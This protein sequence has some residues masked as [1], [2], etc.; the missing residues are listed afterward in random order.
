MKKETASISINSGISHSEKANLLLCSLPQFEK[1][2]K[3]YFSEGKNL[4]KNRGLLENSI[5]AKEKLSE[6]TTALAWAWMQG[7]KDLFEGNAFLMKVSEVDEVADIFNYGRTSIGNEKPLRGYYFIFRLGFKKR[8]Q[9]FEVQAIIERIYARWKRQR[10]I[11]IGALHKGG[12]WDYISP[13]DV[14]MIIGRKMDGAVYLPKWDKEV[15][16]TNLKPAEDYIIVQDVTGLIG[17]I[18]DEGLYNPSGCE[19]FINKIRAINAIRGIWWDAKDKGLTG[20]SKKRIKTQKPTKFLSAVLNGIEKGFFTPASGLGKWEKQY[21]TP[22]ITFNTNRVS[23]NGKKL[24]DGIEIRFPNAIPTVPVREKLKKYGFQFSDKQQI[25]YAYDTEATKA[26]VK[27]FANEAVETFDL[28]QIEEL[29]ERRYFWAN[30]TKANA[31]KV[32]ATAQIKIKHH[33]DKIAYYKNIEEAKYDIGFSSFDSAVLAGRVYFKKFYTAKNEQENDQDENENNDQHWQNQE[34]PDWGDNQSNKEI[35]EALRKSGQDKQKQIEELQIS[36]SNANSF[37]RKKELKEQIILA[38]QTRNCCFALAWEHEKMPDPNSWEHPNELSLWKV[39]NAD[40]N[41]S[42]LM[43]TEDGS[44]YQNTPLHNYSHAYNYGFDNWESLNATRLR[45]NDI[46][47]MWNRAGGHFES[48]SEQKK[49]KGKRQK[50]KEQQPKTNEQ[51]IKDLRNAASLKE[52][53][54]KRLAQNIKHEVPNWQGL[55]PVLELTQKEIE[56]CYALAYWHEQRPDPNIWGKRDALSYKID[57]ADILGSII[58]L[59]D[60]NSRMLHEMHKYPELFSFGFTKQEEVVEARQL[61]DFALYHWVQ[62]SKPKKSTIDEKPTKENDKIIL[63]L[64]EIAK[65]AQKEAD[66]IEAKIDM[67]GD[68]VPELLELLVRKRNLVKM[69]YALAWEHKNVPNPYHWGPVEER[70]LYPIQTAE[71]LNFIVGVALVKISWMPKDLNKYGFE[72]FSEVEKANNQIQETISRWEK[73]G[74]PTDEIE[75]PELPGN[76]LDLNEQEEAEALLL[77][78]SLK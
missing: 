57:N 25:W 6:Y 8:A 66:E 30:V 77:L 4:P 68:Y 54:A 55:Q 78:L 34:V 70:V 15:Y 28:S 51:I 50:S 10:Q 20:I 36:L 61:I 72:S 13:K 62:A 2:W 60:N 27:E 67:K 59:T 49:G 32:P 58:V 33:G 5:K 73:A 38:E 40:L 37:V 3:T 18:E 39:N 75:I 45:L 21:V 53:F 29:G 23:K 42:I 48:E 7:N 12:F 9:I 63:N 19:K 14:F 31:T 41:Q 69:A 26:F 76:D 24:P 16:L 43:L 56:Y 52:D 1:T 65:N 64:R 47:R 46:L 35:I 22:E 11:G 71:H 74:R 44:P 17:N